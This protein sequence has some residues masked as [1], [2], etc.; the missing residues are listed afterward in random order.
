MFHS[1]LETKL[2]DV[3]PET[4]PTSQPSEPNSLKTEREQM[5]QA[6]EFQAEHSLPTFV[7][8]PYNF[9]SWESSRILLRK[10]IFLVISTYVSTGLYVP[11]LCSLVTNLIPS[12]LFI[13]QCP[14]CSG[15][16]EHLSHFSAPFIMGLFIFLCFFC[17]FQQNFGRKGEKGHEQT[18]LSVHPLRGL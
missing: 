7:A 6:Y 2:N 1:L 11:L 8:I 15:S 10:F 16:L 14:Q 5:F 12:V 9:H 17:H 4:N 18:C 13:P 3:V